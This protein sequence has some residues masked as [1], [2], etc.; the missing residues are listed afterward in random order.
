MANRLADLDGEGVG[1]R[2]QIDEDE[3]HA[4]RDL[5]LVHREL[6]CLEALSTQDNYITQ[7]NFCQY[8]LTPK[9]LQNFTLFYR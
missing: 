3:P 8:K 9:Y 6:L 2:R 1:E 4:D 5:T 7:T